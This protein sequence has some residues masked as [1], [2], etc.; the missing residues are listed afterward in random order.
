MARPVTR[1]ALAYD[2]MSALAG[3]GGGEVHG[4]ELARLLGRSRSLVSR[5]LGDL[6]RH[7]LVSVRQEGNRRYYRWTSAVGL[8]KRNPR[9]FLV[10]K[11]G[12]RVQTQMP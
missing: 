12:T 9:K 11:A 2:A 10:V 8:L 7:G 3:L 1:A 6:K 4:T 5:S